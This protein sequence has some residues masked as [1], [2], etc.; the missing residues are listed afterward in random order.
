[1]PATVA[2]GLGAFAICLGIAVTL[3]CLLFTIRDRD[4]HMA[5]IGICSAAVTTTMLLLLYA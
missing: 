3:A 5:V 4:R 1:M 2:A